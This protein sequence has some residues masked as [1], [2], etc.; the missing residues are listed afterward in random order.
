MAD[1]FSIAF[2]AIF[3]GIFL[4][5]IT[6]RFRPHKVSLDAIPVMVALAGQLIAI[7]VYVATAMALT[8]AKQRTCFLRPCAPQTIQNWEQAYGLFNLGVLIYEV[9]ADFK[10]A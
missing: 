4:L 5:V 8:N 1:A 7:I 6:F 3:H 2:P 10:R 9:G